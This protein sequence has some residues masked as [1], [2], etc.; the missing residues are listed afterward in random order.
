[1]GQSN[2][3]RSISAQTIQEGNECIKAKEKLKAYY[4]NIYAAC[5]WGQS[6]TQTHLQRFVE[7][8]Q[9][10]SQPFCHTYWENL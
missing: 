6:S 5:G 10:G 7:D 9:L 3:Y 2:M 8:S 1:M 4:P